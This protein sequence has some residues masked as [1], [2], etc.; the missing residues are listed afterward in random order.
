MRRN[1][2]IHPIHTYIHYTQIT[3]LIDA[4]ATGCLLRFWFLNDVEAAVAEG[5]GNI[6]EHHMQ[7]QTR[8]LNCFV[9]PTFVETFQHCEAI[10]W[11]L[12]ILHRIF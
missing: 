4:S 5:G 6:C 3:H 1:A 7:S 12:W 9:R 11:R 2:L 8:V 10:E